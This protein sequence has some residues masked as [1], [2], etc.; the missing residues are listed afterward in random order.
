MK[1]TQNPFSLYDFLGYFIPGCFFIYSILLINRGYDFTNYSELIDELTFHGFDSYFPF[2]IFSYVSGHFISFLSSYSIEKY[3]IW[4]YGYPSKLLLNLPH[5]GY[6]SSAGSVRNFLVRSIVFLA[7]LPISLLDLTFGV[8]FG[9]KYWNNKKLD[10]FLVSIILSNAQ[11]AITHIDKQG[12]GG[13]INLKKHD[14]FSVLYHYVLERGKAHTVKIQNYVAI[15]GFLRCITFLFVLLFW[16]LLYKILFDN[17]LATGKFSWLI[18]ISFL[19]YIFFLSFLKFYK[20]F[21]RE[22]LMALATMEH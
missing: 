15:Y 13:S 11:H 7:L 9:F 14:F 17:Q 1:F 18:A 16:F 3:S 22:T 21:T 2:I 19:A 20:R 6:Y 5:N 8:L 10:G 4:R 12:E